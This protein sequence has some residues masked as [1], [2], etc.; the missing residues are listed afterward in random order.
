MRRRA[1]P[2]QAWKAAA[3][4]FAGDVESSKPAPDLVQVAL[5][6]VGVSAE[7]AV[8]TDDTVWDVRACR[9]AGVPC[10]GPAERRHQR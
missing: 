2:T 4:T 8:F 5:E 1:R 10:I 7:E 3:A 6:R 9:K